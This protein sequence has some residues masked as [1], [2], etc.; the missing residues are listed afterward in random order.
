MRTTAPAARPLTRSLPPAETYR[1]VAWDPTTVLAGTLRGT[2]LDVAAVPAGPRWRDIRNCS[3]VANGSRIVVSAVEAST[4]T[5]SLWRVELANGAPELLIEADYLLYGAVEPSGARVAFTSPPSRGRADLSLSIFDVATRRRRLMLDGT[6]ARSCVPSWRSPGAILIH[7]ENRQIVEVDTDSGELRQLGSG[8][9]PAAAPDGTRIAYLD[10]QT[11]RLVR[12]DWEPIGAFR[13]PRGPHR[14][15][16]SWSPD[17]RLLLL[18]HAAGALREELRFGL[19]DVGSMKYAMIRR[20]YL[21]GM[22]FS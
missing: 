13:L 4:G 11:V 9:Y 2:E 1:V 19:I 18:A 10:G 16:M 7:T 20:R 6:V 15:A 21:Y 22:V 14:G 12:G 8:E 17:G 5:G 3:A